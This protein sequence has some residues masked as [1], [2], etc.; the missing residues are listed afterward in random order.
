MKYLRFLFWPVLC[1][2]VGMSASALQSDALRDWYPFLHKPLL[3]PPGW[4]FALVWIVLYILMGLSMSLVQNSGRPGRGVATGIFLLQL[5]VN[6]S[7]STVFFYLRSP[8][9]GLVIISA[10]FAL[11]L[12]Y[13]WKSLPLSR[14]GAYLFL[15]YLAWV[16]FAWYLNFSIVL[17]N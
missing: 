1:L 8:T 17:H 9:A 13:V 4:V 12:L 14:M 5:A 15:P 2:A 7:W 3:T 11:L 6:F 10:L 16:G